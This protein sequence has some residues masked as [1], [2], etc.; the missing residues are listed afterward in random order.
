MHSTVHTSFS[1]PIY[2][3]T[4]NMCLTS[5]HG[6]WSFGRPQYILNLAGE[7]AA[8]RVGQWLV[9]GK[10][11]L[12]GGLSPVS[13]CLCQLVG[14][15]TKLHRL[16]IPQGPHSSTIPH[17]VDSGGNR[18]SGGAG[19]GGG[20]GS[21][22]ELQGVGDSGYSWREELI[23]IITTGLYIQLLTI[24]KGRVWWCVYVNSWCSKVQFHT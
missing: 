16:S 2:V 18:A 21:R 12:I 20:W 10:H 22:G 8:Y 4:K 15:P 9:D 1:P 19:Q 7:G 13:H 23:V 24:I 11:I 17:E 3:L 5:N 14:D 6:L